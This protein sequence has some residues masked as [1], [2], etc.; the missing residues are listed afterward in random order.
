MVTNRFVT[1]LPR[2]LEELPWTIFVPDGGFTARIRGVISAARRG[3]VREF[4]L[5]L[6]TPNSLRREVNTARVR[7][8][9]DIK[10][11]HPDEEYP[12]R[13]FFSPAV[14]FF[15][16]GNGATANLSL[17]NLS[18][19]INIQDMAVNDPTGELIA[20]YPEGQSRPPIGME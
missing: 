9:P 1:E 16:D 6:R 8:F 14:G 19:R 15:L 4:E 3:V 7:V 20:W 13:F 11:V 10:N 17:L 18:L 2:E 12:T 5:S